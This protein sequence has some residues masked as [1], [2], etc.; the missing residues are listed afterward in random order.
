[1]TSMTARACRAQVN[2]AKGGATQVDRFPDA[3]CGR[4]ASIAF[5]FRA[6]ETNFVNGI[7]P[8]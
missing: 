3:S 6:G 1:M 7:N 4:D 2:S 5:E 8:I